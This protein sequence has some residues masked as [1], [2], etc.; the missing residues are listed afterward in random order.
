MNS[1]EEVY[2]RPADIDDWARLYAW[3]IDP[4]VRES[5]RNSGE[6]TIGEHMEWLRLR[7]V[8]QKTKILIAFLQSTGEAIGTGRLDFDGVEG[9]ELSIVIDPDRRGV[10]L[11][12]QTIR[13]LTMAVHG[14]FPSAR[15]VSALVLATNTASLRAFASSGFAPSAMTRTIMGDD[16]LWIGL[17]RQQE[18]TCENGLLGGVGNTTKPS[19]AGS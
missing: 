16:R 6:F 12:A 8:D 9:V 4:T 15:T 2:L 1:N 3:R 19:T 18:A 13:A 5:S 7:L 14:Y 11:G 17:I 10:G